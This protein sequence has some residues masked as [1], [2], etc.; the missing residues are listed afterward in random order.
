MHTTWNIFHN[1]PTKQSYEIAVFKWSNLRLFEREKN[2]LITKRYLKSLPQICLFIGLIHF[3]DA[4]EIK[5]PWEARRW[6][7]MRPNRSKVCNDP[8]WT[9]R[10]FRKVTIS[11]QKMRTWHNKRIQSWHLIRK[12]DWY[13]T[14]QVRNFSRIDKQPSVNK[15]EYQ[16]HWSHKPKQ[17]TVQDSTASF[18]SHPIPQMIFRKIYISLKERRYI[19]L[20]MESKSQIH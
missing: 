8:L 20:G 15:T 1:F 4:L 9:N 16:E 17:K 14:H 3:S 5:R 7:N 6:W 10:I 13:V 12:K 18:T 2:M 19:L 11:N